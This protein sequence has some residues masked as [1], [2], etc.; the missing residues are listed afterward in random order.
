MLLFFCFFNFI[1]YKLRQ[2][3]TASETKKKQGACIG[4]LMKMNI[5]S[6]HNNYS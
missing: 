5:L 3:L 4:A 6:C 1:P 2:V